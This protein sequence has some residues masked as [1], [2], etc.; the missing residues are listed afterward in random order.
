M[1]ERFKKNYKIDGWPIEDTEESVVLTTNECISLLNKQAN[2]IN[3]L[4]NMLRKKL[5]LIRC[6]IGS[7]Y[8]GNP[9]ENDLYVEV[10]SLL[11]LK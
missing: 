9:Y 1:N 5:D 6:G 10:K 2:Q 3:D 7:N 4:E 8:S 11:E